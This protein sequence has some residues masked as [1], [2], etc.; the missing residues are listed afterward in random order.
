MPPYVWMSPICLDPLYVWIPHRFGCPISLD[1]PICLDALY[2][3][4][5]PHISV[6]PHAP[7]YICLFLGDICIRYGDGGIYTPHIECSDAITRKIYKKHYKFVHAGKHI[8][9]SKT[10]Y[11]LYESFIYLSEGD[12]GRDMNHL[13]DEQTTH[14]S[15]RPPP[16][17]P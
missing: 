14:I 11:D 1:T 17:P 2:M 13:S 10:P 4:E 16:G 3:S 7:L 9:L 15:N 6:C 5:C 8:Y 12:L